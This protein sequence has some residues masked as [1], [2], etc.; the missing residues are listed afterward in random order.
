MLRS[1]APKPQLAEA[2]NMYELRSTGALVNYLH[3]D[4]FSPTKSF[5]LKAVN[6]Q[7]TFENDASNRDGT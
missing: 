4:C 1:K 5:F 2:N 3:N 6:D 7:Q